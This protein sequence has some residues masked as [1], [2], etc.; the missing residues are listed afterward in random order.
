[1]RC[2]EFPPSRSSR[3]SDESSIS[4]KL[5]S[6]KRDREIE[7][8]RE[9]ERERDSEGERSANVKACMRASDPLDRNI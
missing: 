2:K 6:N 1:M 8:E 3:L 5:A 7:I 4:M 9:R